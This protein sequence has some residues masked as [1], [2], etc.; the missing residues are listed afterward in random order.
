MN[1][2]DM[3]HNPTRSLCRGLHTVGWW[4]LAGL[5]L[6][7]TLPGQAQTTGLPPVP[8]DMSIPACTVTAG[9][10]TV[11]FGSRS[12]GQL[13]Q[14]AGGLSPGE[15]TIMVSAGCTLPRVMRLRVDGPGRGSA[16]SWGGTDSA[17]RIRALRAGLDGKPVML[18]RLSRAGQ[19]AEPERDELILTPGDVLVATD[20]GQ[21]ASGRQL[22]VTLEV[23]PVLGERD[24]R[25]V[26][27]VYPESTLTISLVPQA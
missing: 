3:Q 11:D 27:R 7:V 12:R 4:G 26:H 9:S 10:G 16:F 1:N 5:L 25:P 6:A 14:V 2:N 24:S 15:R 21:P 13:Q 22:T 23:V 19:P 8:P 20:N 18:K 17:L